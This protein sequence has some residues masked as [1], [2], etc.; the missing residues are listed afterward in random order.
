[1]KPRMA[2]VKTIVTATPEGVRWSSFFMQIGE[3]AESVVQRFPAAQVATGMSVEV[4][5]IVS[6][7]SVPLVITEQTFVETIFVV[8]QIKVDEL[9]DE[10]VDV[11]A[12]EL[13]LEVV[14]VM[15]L[16]EDAVLA[17]EDI[18]VEVEESVVV[19]ASVDEG[20]EEVVEDTAAVVFVVEVLLAVLFPVAAADVESVA[21][22]LLSSPRPSGSSY[23]WQSRANHVV[24]II[25][26]AIVHPAAMKHCSISSNRSRSISVE[27]HLEANM[28]SPQKDPATSPSILSRIHCVPFADTNAAEVVSRLRRIGRM[29]KVDWAP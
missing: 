26:S 10:P 25:A 18:D 11:V 19:V 16:V 27:R 1:M 28:L 5:P 8:E 29:A 7:M 22:L 3:P 13:E 15:L 9:D 20:D 12:L 6:P 4:Q 14:V 2:A 24:S 21:A 23:V 17:V